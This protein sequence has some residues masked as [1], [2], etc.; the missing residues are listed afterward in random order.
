MLILPVDLLDSAQQ[1]GRNG[2]WDKPYKMSAFMFGV[3]FKPVA[4]SKSLCALFSLFAPML[5]AIF[6]T[7]YIDKAKILFVFVH[8]T[9]LRWC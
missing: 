9:A 8:N 4:A 2:G 3:F 1:K 6:T 7:P 5:A